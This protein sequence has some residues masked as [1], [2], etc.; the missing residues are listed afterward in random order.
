MKGLIIGLVVLLLL[1]AGITLYVYRVDLKCFS[2]DDKE[3]CKARVFCS[4]EKTP[5]SQD[6]CFMRYGT[7]FSNI[8]ICDEAKNGYTIS[9]CYKAIAL[10]T[11]ES[12]TCSIIPIEKSEASIKRDCYLELATIKKDA[13]LCQYIPA[14]NRN[15]GISNGDISNG[16]ISNGDTTPSNLNTEDRSA[17][18]YCKVLVAVATKDASIC[19]TLE[20]EDYVSKAICEKRAKAGSNDIME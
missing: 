18:D 15:P 8:K 19:Q 3:L 4:S 13:S 7:Q 20:S 10:A 12:Y 6:M 16:D 17:R 2:A 1:V 9:N 5:E 11:Q 14:E